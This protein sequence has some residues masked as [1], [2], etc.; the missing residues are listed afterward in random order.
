M[1]SFGILSVGVPLPSEQILGPDDL[2]SRTFPHRCKQKY[3]HTD[4]PGNIIDHRE[5]TDTEG[6]STF[7]YYSR[8][9]WNSLT[10]EYYTAVKRMRS[11]FINWCGSTSKMYC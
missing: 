8:N 11:A 10:A 1:A 3:L 6:T 2:I 4:I 7:R 5:K 9:V